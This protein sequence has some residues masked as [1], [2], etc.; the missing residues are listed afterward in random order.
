LYVVAIP[1]SRADG[2]RRRY[3]MF[4]VLSGSEEFAYHGIL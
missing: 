3:W 4:F 1:R 2:R